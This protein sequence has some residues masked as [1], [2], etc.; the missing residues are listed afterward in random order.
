MTDVEERLEVASVQ[1]EVLNEIENLI[2]RSGGL[3]AFKAMVGSA[4]G[5]SGALARQS[6][7]VKR[8]SLAD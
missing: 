3:V 1:V 4:C 5:W 2:T 8:S 6:A 7:H